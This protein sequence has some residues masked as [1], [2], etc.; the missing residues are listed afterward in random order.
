[1][2]ARL[3]TAQPE[4]VEG[5]AIGVWWGRSVL[6]WEP[7]EDEQLDALVA[8]GDPDLE[9]LF[10]AIGE[11]AADPGDKLGGWPLDDETDDEGYWLQISAG[12]GL[13]NEPVRPGLRVEVSDLSSFGMGR[14]Y[15]LLDE[16]SR[17][18]ARVVP[19]Y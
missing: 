5:E 15:V 8:E 7:F 17:F 2:T 14:A 6:R 10:D 11:R 1:M 18:G 9:E 4:A 3:E 13:D 19:T 12:G 16:G